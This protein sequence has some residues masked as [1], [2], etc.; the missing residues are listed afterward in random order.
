MTDIRED[1]KRG[2]EEAY[3][4]RFYR[5][6]YRLLLAGAALA[7]AYTE[8][9]FQAKKE[10]RTEF[11]KYCEEN[12]RLDENRL[13]DEDAEFL[14]RFPVYNFDVT[15]DSEIGKW[16]NREYEAYFGPFA[17]WLIEG[18]A[19]GVPYE[20]PSY[21]VRSN[22]YWPRD[23]GPV[24]ELMLLLTAYEHLDC[25][26]T[27]GDESAGFGRFAWQTGHDQFVHRTNYTIRGDTR[28]VSV[29]SVYSMWKR[30]P[31]RF[32]SRILWTFSALTRTRH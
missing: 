30:S 12:G 19:K 22:G 28:K 13:T 17:S 8:P 4:D 26:F 14:R 7:R 6:M 31:C 23:M 15:D 11:L 10:G 2:D 21:I 5:A 29:Y 32:G 27:N 25:K 9:L 16:R 20:P 1:P 18:R 3:K 24:Q